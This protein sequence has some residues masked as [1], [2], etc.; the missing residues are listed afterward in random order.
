MRDK[1]NAANQMTTV[2]NKLASRAGLNQVARR[3]VLWSNKSLAQKTLHNNPYPPF[4]LYC[5]KH[6][7][8]VPITLW[9]IQISST[10]VVLH[11]TAGKY[12][13]GRGHHFYHHDLQHQHHHQVT[14]S[15]SHSKVVIGVGSSIGGGAGVRDAP[16]ARLL[17]K[18][19]GHLLRFRTSL[20]NALRPPKPDHE[21]KTPFREWKR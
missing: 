18:H 12:C 6:A 20:E 16:T 15:P 1:V 10:G 13:W 7:S 11:K 5:L 19:G 21:V 8:T 4:K 3:A 14:P 2:L 17:D 9:N